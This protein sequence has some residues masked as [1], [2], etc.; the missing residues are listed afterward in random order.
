MDWIFGFLAVLV[1][2]GILSLL[3]IVHE[4]GHFSVAR[5]FGFQTPVF[6]IGLPFGP[7]KVVGHRWGT[8]FRIY[9]ACLLG[10]FVAIPEL[11]D[12]TNAREEN[13]GVP[14]K[15]FKK[16]PIWQRAL[17]AFAGV[18][19]NI[20]FAWLIYFNMLAFMGEPTTT[21]VVAALPPGNPIAADAGIKAGDQIVAI[22]DR[23]IK[24]T[25]DV[26]AYLGKH[27]N[28]QVVM[29]LKRPVGEAPADST[30]EVPTTAVDIP[31]T[32]N[33]L[34]K[35]GMALDQTKNKFVPVNLG[36]LELAS[37]STTDL[38]E[39]TGNIRSRRR[40]PRQEPLPRSASETC[41]ACWR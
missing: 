40:N 25:T 27:A 18:G 16:F 8:E 14:L 13:F 38:V 10:G 9:Y 21:V 37:K 33:K 26:I 12:E 29:H 11:G 3:I 31:V 23:T 34:G 36:P 30:A 7:H 4:F 28:Q 41:T 24:T 32:P 22:D 5:L 1:M 15:P 20:L 17:V 19:F 6:G 39:L 2:L 35:V